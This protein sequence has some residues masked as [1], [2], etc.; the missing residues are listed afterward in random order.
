MD[1]KVLFTEVNELLNQ[2]VNEVDE[3][4]IKSKLTILIG[5]LQ[6][7]DTVIPDGTFD[8]LTNE[9]RRLSLMLLMQLALKSI[10]V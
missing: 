5:L 8:I 6:D 9:N 1:I 4:R 10:N 3:N 2:T 7:E